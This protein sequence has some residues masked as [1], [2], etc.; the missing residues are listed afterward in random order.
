[1]HASVIAATI[2]GVS[3]TP[4]VVELFTR[5]FPGYRIVGLPDAAC[6][7]SRDRV[8]AAL[9]SAGFDYP[10]LGITINLAPSAQRKGGAGL[11]LAIALGLLVASEQ[12]EP[13]VLADLAALGE[14]GLDG[15]VRPLAGVAPMVAAV[16]ERTMLVPRANVAEAELVAAGTIRCADTLQQVVSC[17]RGAEPWPDVDPPIVRVSRD[18]VP[19]LADVRG[20]PA[21]RRALEISAAGG[22]H[23]LLIGPPGSG[24]SMLARRLPGLLPHLDRRAAIEVAMV[25]S[26]A[27]LPVMAEALDVPPFRDPHHTSSVVALVGG[28]S[29]ALRPGEVSLAHQG[30]LFMDELG[31]FSRS[32]LEGLREPL[33]EGQVRVARAS[34]RATMPAAFLLVAATNPCPCGGGAP[35]ECDCDA[36]ARARYLRRLSGPLLDRFD[37]RVVVHR[38]AVGELL[39][40]PPGETTAQVRERVGL[41][42]SMAMTRQGV[43]NAAIAAAD[44]D[45]LAPLAVDAAELLRGE[46]ETGRLSGRGYHR[47]RRVARTVADLGG[48][49]APLLARHVAVALSLRVAVGAV[50][51]VTAARVR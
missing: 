28:G 40:G 47:V 16:G 26:A 19:D 43:P 21:A 49:D 35:G 27:G 24:K 29:H 23:L 51:Q 37:L 45:E 15:A 8:R 14:L 11:D 25:R 6:R 1:M 9:L 41:A 42:R 5:G 31:E 33:E 44:I 12:L 18:T 46:L 48:H 7:E 38:P 34:V 22:H 2:C 36:A 3:G 17:L 39:D 30:V 20:Q 10:Q 32:A 4:V 50:P 13:A